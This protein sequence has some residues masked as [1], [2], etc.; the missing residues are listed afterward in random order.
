MKPAVASRPAPSKK[1]RPLIAF[2]DPVNAATQRNKPSPC[3]GASNLTADF[4]D[5]FARSL[6]T[7]DSPCTNITKLTEAP[8]CQLGS[9]C[10]SNNSAT[11]CRAS[12][13]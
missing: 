5:I 9:S 6:A 8:I 3:V 12:P 1:P 10:V 11:T 4:D 7:P 13:P 2:L